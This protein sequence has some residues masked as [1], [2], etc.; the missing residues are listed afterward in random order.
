MSGHK[1]CASEKKLMTSF[2]IVRVCS[3]REF[4]SLAPTRPPGV[5][6]FKRDCPVLSFIHM[7]CCTFRRN[8]G[9]RSSYWQLNA[10]RKYDP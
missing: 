9:G 1:N 2:L 4:K 3:I 8:R 10:R 7:G 6:N 5:F